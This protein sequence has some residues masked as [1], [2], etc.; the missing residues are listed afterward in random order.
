MNFSTAD[1]VSSVINTMKTPE[2]ARAAQ[3]A[4]LNDFFNGKPIWTEEEA[5]SNRI[6]V[7]FNDKTGSVL[8]QTARSQYTN[9]FMC[10][11]SY[12]RVS[13]GGAPDDKAESW[14]S[15][16]TSKL[17]RVIMKS[18]AFAQVQDE[19][20]GGVVLHGIG[21][22]IWYDGHDWCPS[23]V[24]PQ[25]LLIPTDTNLMMDNLQ[26]FAVRRGM[27]PG[28]L[29]Q[30]TFGSGDNM[31][32]GWNKDAVQRILDNYK[33][34]NSNPQNYD[35]S[36]NPEQMSELYKQNASYYDSDSAPV[37]WMWDFFFQEEEG[38]PSENGWYRRI[39]LD[40]DS[41]NGGVA[42]LNNVFLYEAQKP[43]ANQLD[44]VIHFQF[45]DGN[46]VPPFKYH[47]IRSLAFLT[48]E[49]LWTMNR[50]RCQ[51]TQHVFEQ[52][53]TIFRV[54]D[55]SDR[56]RLQ[57]VVMDSPW[58]IIP[59]GLSIVPASER[60][61][62]NANLV[63]NIRQ[64]Y[65]EL[66]SQS[67]STYTQNPDQGAI[68]EKTKFQVQAELAQTSSL[69]GNMLSR[70]YRQ[71]LFAAM[72]ICRRFTIRDST[73]FAVKK[74]LNECQQEGIPEKYLDISRWDV[75]IE[76]KL[77]Q[78]N[79]V[80]EVAEAGQLM[81]A[82]QQ[83]DPDSHPE[84][85]HRWV[86]AVTANPNLA[87]RISKLDSAPKVS[88]SVHDAELAF[89]TL[90]QGVPVSLKDGIN[91]TETVDTTLRLMTMV[92]RQIMQGGG[93][94]TQQQIIGLQLAAQ[95]AGG[96]LQL[97]AQDPAEKQKVKEFGDVLGQIMN[98]VKAFA[99]RQAESQQSG[100]SGGE[101]EG[102]MAATAA[103]LKGEVI[104]AQSKAQIA[105]AAAAQKRRHKEKQFV[106]KQGMDTIK[107]EAEIKRQNLLAQAQAFQQGMRSPL[108]S[109][110]EE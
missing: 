66:V 49:L 84:I 65:A 105:E 77:G 20:F 81:G 69:M 82:L 63:Q 34:L 55:P 2:I 108:Q 107:T 64:E 71:E 85:K 15:I 98:Q 72:E 37:I 3:R 21:A 91:R 96:H 101:A 10:N 88:D 68:R 45:G 89:G 28:E 14:S 8:L 90:M 93:V 94:G 92:V 5:S 9:A 7:N 78:G 44:E 46:N 11:T 13:I 58:G 12:C 27:R 54:A 70:A 97:I 6:T 61:A 33:E 26:Y 23:F 18:R 59:D 36:N 56:S 48:Y 57:Q 17:N 109:T 38:A 110:S 1:K 4:I 99:Q 24:G 87:R 86:M 41:A 47:S 42:D 19:V 43:F 62:V 32:P 80:M 76:Q 102:E 35:W 106:Q 60:Y 74:F 53:L 83:F 30:K 104:K 31:D 75:E 95:Y 103:K 73:D 67:S 50:L 40:S 51:W 29:F 100:P 25:D 39:V 22:K 16:V 79:R 52:M